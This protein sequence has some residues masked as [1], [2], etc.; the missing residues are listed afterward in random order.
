MWI[1]L[2][3]YVVDVIRAIDWFKQKR[4]TKK[5]KK[6][7]KV[8]KIITTA[9]YCTKEVALTTFPSKK[10]LFFLSIHNLK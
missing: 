1:P 7:K 4:R 5:K 2:S 10:V 8:Y 6:K 3:V 9:A